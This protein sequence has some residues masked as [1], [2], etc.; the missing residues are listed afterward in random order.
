MC[1]TLTVLVHNKI[2]L[3]TE[4]H[5]CSKRMTSPNV[6]KKMKHLITKCASNVCLSNTYN[7]INYKPNTIC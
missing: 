6:K 1:C 2:I 7:S 3:I 4:L 5:S